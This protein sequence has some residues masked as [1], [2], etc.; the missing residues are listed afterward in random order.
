MTRPQSTGPDS[1]LPPRSTPREPSSDRSHGLE[2]RIAELEG[3]TT[4]QEDQIESLHKAL[5]EQTLILE[6]LQ[7]RVEQWVLTLRQGTGDEPLPEHEK[8]PHY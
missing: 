1:P 2:R 8:P 6:G 7:K 5:Y 4:F 3:R